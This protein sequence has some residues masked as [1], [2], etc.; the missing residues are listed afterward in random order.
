MIEFRSVRKTFADANGKETVA[1]HGLDLRI[2]P[3]QVHC[4]IGTS[5]CGKTTSLRLVN[6]L[7]EP[8]SGQVLVDGEDVREVDVIALRRRIGYVIQSGGLFPHLT[9]AKNVG[10]LCD[11]EG[12]AA[13]DVEQRVHAL[14][15]LVNLA[16]SK[17]AGR[18]PK[19]LSGGQRQRVGI[20]RALALDPKYLLM[21]EPFGALD[22]LTRGELL[23]ELQSLFS[24]LGKTVLLVTHDL[25]EAFALGQ[26]VSV[27]HAGHLIQTGSREDLTRNPA[28]EFVANF[29]KTAHGGAN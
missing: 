4:L 11:L 23:S 12:H 16:P 13:K 18:Y 20:A 3:G 5:G 26:R 14:L 21:D 19:E 28:T 7:E 15:E 9:I 6:R 24:S 10:V 1:L 8:T 27:M 17:F 25:N 29:V 2:E 22:P